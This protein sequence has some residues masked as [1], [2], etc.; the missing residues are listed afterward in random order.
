MNLRAVII[1]IYKTLLE[2][3]PPQDV[4][5]TW[6]RLWRNHLQTAPRLGPDEFRVQADRVI[7]DHHRAAKSV[8]IMH[9]EIFWPD[10]VQ[11]VLPELRQLPALVRDD[12]L[13]EQTKCWHSTRLMPG[14]PAVLKT[15]VT[16][17]VPLGIASNSQSY[18]LR[19]MDLALHGSEFTRES[20]RPDLSFF[21]YAHGFSKPDA[22]VFRDLSARLALLGI[23]PAET[24]MVGDRLDNDILPARLQGWQTWQLKAEPDHGAGPGGSWSALGEWLV[25]RITSARDS[26]A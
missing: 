6:E 10:V 1:D 16:A 24:L 2:V 9:P 23:A 13:F 8:G 25:D 7:A 22:H 5:A 18:T 26:T 20:F 12:F 19:E 14:A 17:G 21:S 15:L 4:T 11:E 3:G